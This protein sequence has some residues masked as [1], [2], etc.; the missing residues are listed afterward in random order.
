MKIYDPEDANSLVPVIKEKLALLRIL[1][2]QLKNA[3]LSLNTFF[4]SKN[5]HDTQNY[6]MLLQENEKIKADINEQLKCFEERNIFIRDIDLG[7]VDFYAIRNNQPV[8]LCWIE[9]V[10]P[11]VMYY[12]G[13]ADSKNG[14]RPIKKNDTWFKQIVLN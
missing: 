1:K 4:A 10:E 14:R 3:E 7:I 12:H 8:Y 9:R 6:T 2:T 5:S 13:L 11:K